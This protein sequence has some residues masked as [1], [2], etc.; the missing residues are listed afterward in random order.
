M[1]VFELLKKLESNFIWQNGV[2]V[3]PLFYFSKKG[4]VL[5]VEHLGSHVGVMNEDRLQQLAALLA[6]VLG[7][8][9]LQLHDVFEYLLDV[10]SR[11][12]IETSDHFTEHY[13]PTPN[14]TFITVPNLLRQEATL[15]HPRH[16]RAQFLLVDNLRRHVLRCPTLCKRSSFL[17]S[18]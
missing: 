14:I 15:R 13:S 11:K 10:A 7:P 12:W 2:K 3:P 1:K 5:D 17:L 4:V 18:T 16:R 8:V 9:D 6:D